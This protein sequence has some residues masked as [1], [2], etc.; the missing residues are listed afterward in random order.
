[1]ADDKKSGDKPRQRPIQYSAP[2]SYS[3]PPL[4]GRDGVPRPGSP[5]APTPTPLDIAS[6]PN[7]TESKPLPVAGAPP[8]PDVETVLH[9]QDLSQYG[10]R[11]VMSESHESQPSGVIGTLLKKH[12]SWENLFVL[13]VGDGIGL[14]L[15]IAA[16]DA[17][18]K[19]NWGP[20]F[21]GFGIG[22]P[23]MGIASSFPFWKNRAGKWLR[24]S[25]VNISTGGA[26][27]VVLAGCVY[28]LGPYIL[29]KG[30]SP[31]ANDIAA[32]VADKLKPMLS[33]DVP[34]ATQSFGFAPT[35]LKIPT[36][37]YSTDEKQELLELIG[38]I[39]KLLN[40]QGMPAAQLAR[41][42]GYNAVPPSKAGLD[43][44]IKRAESVRDSLAAIQLK[45][46]QDIL[47]AKN[48]NYLDD[49]N[50]IVDNSAKFDQFHNATEQFLGTVINF[51]RNL[52][53]FNQDQR[54][55][56]TSLIQE[57]VGQNWGRTAE[58][59]RGYIGQ[60]NARM[61]KEREALE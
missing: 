26:A 17:A 25:I 35:E 50:F 48:S 32:A 52:D 2:P 6:Y 58:E 37:N 53:S 51:E 18:L 36:K 41:V 16:G 56:I 12:S 23:L 19:Q 33:Q 45:I 44:A 3:P 27:F 22:L 9:E 1:M 34:A 47:Q 30:N 31:S 11:A 60:C 5:V 49:L 42:T 46:W 24:D 55:W 43:D 29:P 61:N 57:G 20:M 4:G 15:C 14:S 21:A 38:T 28:V 8:R 54:N 59:F 7:T 13:L 10:Y 39:S 40:D